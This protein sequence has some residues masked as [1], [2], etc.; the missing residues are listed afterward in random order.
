[1][2]K[3]TG[4]LGA[5]ALFSM[6]FVAPALSADTFTWSTMGTS[7]NPIVKCG[8]MTIAAQISK[9][10]G[11]KQEIHL[12]QSAFAN[13]RKLYP[14]LAR[15]VTDFTWGILSY[16]PGR[17]PLTEIVSLPFVAQDNKAA[18]YA[19]NKLAPKYLTKEFRDI[20]LLAIAIPGLYQIISKNRP[21]TCR[22]A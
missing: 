11:R 4:T 3:L 16:T 21:P 10:T 22:Q 17:F 2:M 15:G 20:K 18:S 1:M 6:T 19:I 5:T 8:P 9:I 13:P 14:Q 12:G 7:R